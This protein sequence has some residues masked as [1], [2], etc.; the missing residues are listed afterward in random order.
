MLDASSM[1]LPAA[2]LT[3]PAS[4]ILLPARST[5]QRFSLALRWPIGNAT[6]GIPIGRVLPTCKTNPHVPTGNNI[7]KPSQGGLV[8]PSAADLNLPCSSISPYS[9]GIQRQ[10]GSAFSLEVDSQG[11]TAHKLGL[12]IGQ[13]QPTPVVKDPTQHF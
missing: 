2:Y 10:R 11:S 8:S 9:L 4:R 1:F 7:C 13:T 6:P 12:F 5:V 3:S